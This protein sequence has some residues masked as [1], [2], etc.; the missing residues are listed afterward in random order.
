MPRPDEALLGLAAVGVL[1]LGTLQV[2]TQPA[3]V[4]D[5]PAVAA[6]AAP[7]AAR[8]AAARPSGVRV[9]DLDLDRPLVPLGRLADGSLEV[10]S[11]FDDVGVW[12]GEGPVVLAG[13]VDS[14]TGPAVFAR[15]GELRPGDRVEVRT[16]TGAVQAYAVDRVETHPKD[17]FPTF[18][19]FTG[20]G[21]RLVTCGGAFDR[22]AGSYRDNVVVWATAV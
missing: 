19:V 22:R 17:D 6:P 8:P 7:P 11:D 14:T 12:T 18:E 16:S 5:R 20:T 15:L 21:L 13:H 9:P 1:L 3:P 10:P 4:G 2:L